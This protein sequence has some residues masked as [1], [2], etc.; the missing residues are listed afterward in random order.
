MGPSAKLD[1]LRTE[2]I[3]YAVFCA[4]VELARGGYTPFQALFHIAVIAAV[5]WYLVRELQQKSSLVWA[6]GVVLGL[7][8]AIG[9]AIALVIALRHGD[10]DCDALLLAASVIIHIRVF[11]VLRNRE[12]KHFVM[13]DA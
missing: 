10:L 7:T 9:R 11:G 6:F 4:I 2:W 5:A 3:L 1:R 8:G 13:L 12:V